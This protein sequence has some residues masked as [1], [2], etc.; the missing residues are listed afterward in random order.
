MT[1]SSKTRRPTSPHPFVE[2]VYAPDRDFQIGC[3]PP[4]PLTTG[5]CS[6]FARQTASVFHGSGCSQIPIAGR[7]ARRERDR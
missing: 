6:S 5:A 7:R 4:S 1:P 3:S 2:R